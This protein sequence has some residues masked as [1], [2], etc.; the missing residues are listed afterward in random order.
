MMKGPGERREAPEADVADLRLA[1]S[2]GLQAI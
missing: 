2:D 1:L